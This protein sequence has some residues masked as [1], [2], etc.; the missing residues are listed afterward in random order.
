MA[1]LSWL[2]YYKQCSPQKMFKAPFFA[3][4]N[5]V[6]TINSTFTCMGTFCDL[7]KGWNCNF[8]KIMYVKMLISSTS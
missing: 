5:V 2:S 8:M 1:Q 4:N 3:R 6:R 7:Q